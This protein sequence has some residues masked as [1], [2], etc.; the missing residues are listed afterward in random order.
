MTSQL[1][2]KGREGFLDGSIDWNTG[3]IKVSLLRGYTF[4]DAHQVLSDVTGS[5]ATIV[6]TQT[7][8][9]PTVAGGVANADP[10]TFNSV[11]TGTACSC[12]ILYQSSA[13]GGGADLA[14]SAQRL[15][16]Y[17][18]D[19]TNLPVTPN[20]GNINIAWDSGPNKIFKL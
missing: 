12:Y 5:G 13:P 8:T 7:L 4:N 18:D 16:A 11:P 15:I 3:T 1:Y 17:I 6:A 10:V 20:G 14:T 2:S 9:T 19:A